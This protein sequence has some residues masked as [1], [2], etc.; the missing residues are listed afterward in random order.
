MYGG[1]DT[2]DSLLSDLWCFDGTNKWK[3]ITFDGKQ[4]QPTARSGCS[5][6]SFALSCA[7]EDKTTTTTNTHT[8]VLFAGQA[9]TG[10][11]NDVYSFDVGVLFCCCFV[12]VVCFICCLCVFIVCV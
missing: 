2:K 6:V 5:L 7:N 12:V 3:H 1:E 8:L 9:K 10:V 11:L 4:T